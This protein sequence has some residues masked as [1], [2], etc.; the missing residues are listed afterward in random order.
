M[1]RNYSGK[2]EEK[3]N[4]LKENEAQIHLIEKV[5]ISQEKISKL[6]IRIS[7]YRLT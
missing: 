4:N 6:A 5:S 3:D 2:S 1:S 7:E